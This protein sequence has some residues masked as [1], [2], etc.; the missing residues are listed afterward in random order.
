MSVWIHRYLFYIWTIVQSYHYF[1]S[2]SN[3]FTFGPQELLPVSTM[4][5]CCVPILSFF[6]FFL[7]HLLSFWYHRMCQVY[8]VFF[9]PAP[10][11]TIS[12]RITGSV[13]WQ[14]VFKNQNRLLGVLSAA[15][16]SLCL[17]LFWAREHACLLSH[18]SSRRPVGVFIRTASSRWELGLWP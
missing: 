12:P 3:Y 9:L 1:F 5:L 13:Y 11:S 15:G 16:V 10:R 6:L 2:H 4:F 18:K 8:L 17:D 14:K 7:K